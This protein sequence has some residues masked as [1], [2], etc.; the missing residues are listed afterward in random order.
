MEFDVYEL[1]NLAV[2]PSYK[3]LGMGTRILEE[4]VREISRSGAR[5]MFLE[6]R[7]SN[8]AAL[9]CYRRAGFEIHSCRPGYYQNPPADA[10]V[11][12]LELR[13]P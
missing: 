6:V 9:E 1:L 10:L 2:L 12:R 4:V 11:L 5:E 13:G 3:R 7:T 8:L